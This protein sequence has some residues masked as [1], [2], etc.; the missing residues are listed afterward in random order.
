MA[1]LSTADRVNAAVAA[2]EARATCYEESAH[3]IGA[4]NFT[5]IIC[6]LRGSR[7]PIGSIKDQIG[8]AL[9]V[10]LKSPNATA[11]L[12]L[13]CARIERA[14]GIAHSDATKAALEADA[15]STGDWLAY[16]NQFKANP[17]AEA[18]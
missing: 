16:V 7:V 4:D 15:G 1:R 8:A 12:R 17:K 5:V 2:T 14:L 10:E 3:E 18:A 9:T 11:W 6:D 13:Y